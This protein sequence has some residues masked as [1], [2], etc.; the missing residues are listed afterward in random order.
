MHTNLI[1]D[2]FGQSLFHFFIN[3]LGT[4]KA[5]RPLMDVK[6]LIQKILFVSS[7][8]CSRLL[9]LCLHSCN[10]RHIHRHSYVPIPPLWGCEPQSPCL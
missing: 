2:L 1:V 10:R 3:G 7:N 5:L 9:Y 8:H 6:P 4:K